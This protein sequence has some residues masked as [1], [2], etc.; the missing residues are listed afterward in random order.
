MNVSVLILTLNEEKNLPACLQ[1]VSWCDDVVVFDSLSTDRTVAIATQAGARVIERHFDNYAAQRNAAI[2]TVQYKHSWVL[3]IDADECVSPALKEEIETVLANEPD[4]IT[5]FRIRRKDMFL[6]RW[7]RRSSGYPT[8]F[9]RLFRVGR[10]WVKRQI[11]EEYHTDG[12]IG[13]LNEHLIHCPFN[14]GLDY[15]F[16]RHNRYSS[17]EATSLA[18]EMTKRPSVRGFFSRDPVIR[19]RCLKQWAY[20]LPGRP[21]L[22]FCYLYFVRRGFLDGRAGLAYCR[23][24]RI[25][26][27]MID[28]KLQVLDVENKT[29][30]HPQTQPKTLK[31]V[32]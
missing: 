24:R 20:R 31:K 7:L 3:M 22:V 11:N 9:G 17:M 10:V 21:F 16:E 5:L 30:I 29:Q 4:A 23:L 19:R 18:Q 28:I 12:D 32:A 15:W 27:S 2:H 26:E 14:K 8:W 13:Y 6:G 25:Y 1:S